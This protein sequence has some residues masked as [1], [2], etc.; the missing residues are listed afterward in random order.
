M[1]DT[2]LKVLEDGQN[3]LMKDISDM[4]SSLDG[5]NK[6][7]Q[8]ILVK[9]SEIGAR[10]TISA[11]APTRFMP[12]E[13][14]VARSSSS[15]GECYQ[16]MYARP[17]HKVVDFYADM[18]KGHT[19]LLGLFGKETPADHED[20]EIREDHEKSELVTF[21]VKDRSGRWARVNFKIVLSYH[22]GSFDGW[23]KQPDL[24]TVQG[25]VER[26]LGEFVDEK[27][28]QLLKDKN[29]PLEGCAVVAGRTD[30]GVSASHQ[31]PRRFGESTHELLLN[32]EIPMSPA[33]TPDMGTAS[34]GW[35]PLPRGDT[36]HAGGEPP[37]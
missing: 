14:T 24:N 21:P 1:V 9:F 10:M 19:S 16:F 23:Q 22:G 30:K 27:K 28:A 18:V 31:T 11:P 8:E 4:R 26:S 2:R 20:A 25:L 33:A 5:T 29:L 3:V 32:R 12:L 36:Q 34:S 6:L 7:M 17:W 37:P 13:M 15:G 35:P